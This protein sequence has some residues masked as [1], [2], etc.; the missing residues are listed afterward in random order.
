MANEHVTAAPDAIDRQQREAEEHLWRS[1]LP[2]PFARLAIA[3][4]NYIQHGRFERSLALA[5]AGSSLLS[6]LE[7]SYEHYRGSYGQRVMWTPVILSTALTGAGVWGCIEP[8]TARRPLRW[9]SV[10]TLADC[11]IGFGFHIRGISRRPGGW[12]LPVANIIM[13]PPIFAPLLFGIAAYLGLIASYLLPEDAA[14]GTAH[15]E[16]SPGS[17]TLG[18]SDGS[19]EPRAGW[20]QD[21]REGRFQK[22]LAVAT[23]LSAGFSGFEALYSHYKNN[24]K[25]KAQWSPILIAPALMVAA[26]A[27]I[28]SPKVARTWLPALSLLAIADGGVGFF[29]HARGVLRRPGGLKKPVYNI[30]YGPPIFAPLLFAACGALGLL[31]YAM[32]R[33]RR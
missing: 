8:E 30:M 17:Q 21:I 12:R 7:V 15:R 18:R 32:R 6:G 9:I 3:A 24:F 27:S 14:A 19:P 22:H 13:G 26:F 4:N 2:P 1:V 23:A 5:A 10:L 16:G 25:Y 28:R 31:A 20:E 33:E 29:Y 11:A